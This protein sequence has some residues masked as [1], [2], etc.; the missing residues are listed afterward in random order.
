MEYLQAWQCCLDVVLTLFFFGSEAIEIVTEGT[1][2]I[3]VSEYL[4]CFSKWTGLDTV[5]RLIISQESKQ[6]NLWKGKP[7]K[8]FGHFFRLLKGSS[9]LPLS[10]MSVPAVF[11]SITLNFIVQ[12][13]INWFY[14]ESTLNY[15]VAKR[16]SFVPCFLGIKDNSHICRQTSWLMMIE[17]SNFMHGIFVSFHVIFSMLMGFSILRFKE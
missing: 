16:N 6:K 4:S 5:R 2:Y 9:D 7:G 1:L 10:Y 14:L 17:T 11:E 15:S 13:W 12:R 3:A 8:Q